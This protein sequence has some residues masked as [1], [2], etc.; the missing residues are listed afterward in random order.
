[1]MRKLVILCCVVSIYYPLLGCESSAQQASQ[2][3]TSPS[4]IAVDQFPTIYSASRGSEFWRIYGDQFWVGNIAELREGAS[5]NTTTTINYFQENGITCV[6]LD[7]VS[8]FG[9][10]DTLRVGMQFQC[11]TAQFEVTNCNSSDDCGSALIEGMWRTGSPPSYRDLPV[12]YYYDRCRGIQSI[13]FSLDPELL[14]PIGSSL[15]LRQGLG[16]LATSDS[17]ECSDDLY[18]RLFNGEN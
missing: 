1:M 5:N 9:V 18:Y 17:A 6:N 2:S 8:I 14:N 13:T 12:S 10:P 4:V 11:G 3:S 15:E 7:T 16:L